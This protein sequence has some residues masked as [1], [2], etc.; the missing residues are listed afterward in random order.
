MQSSPSMLNMLIPEMPPEGEIKEERGKSLGVKS[1]GTFLSFIF[2]INQIYGPGVLAI[3]LVYEQSG[4][5]PTMFMVTFFLVV[6][7]LAA[8]CLSQAIAT[9]PGN[10]QYQQRV[11]FATAFEYYYGHKWHVVFQVLLAITVQAYNIASIVICAQSLD[12]AFISLSGETYGFEFGPDFG[13]HSYGNIDSLY[14]SNHVALSLGYLLITAFFMPAGFL[15]LNDNVKVRK[16][17]D[18]R[19]KEMEVDGNC[20]LFFNCLF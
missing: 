6:S 17:K 5:I 16:T 7:S 4:L 11:E 20:D 8:T 1:I 18:T 2:L 3:P 19:G 10:R 13:F 9:I 12:Q 14:K 15:N